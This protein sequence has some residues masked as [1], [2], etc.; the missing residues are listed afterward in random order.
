LFQDSCSKGRFYLILFLSTILAINYFLFRKASETSEQWVVSTSKLHEQITDLSEDANKLRTLDE[1]FEQ[2][3]KMLTL[4]RS[5]HEDLILQF[6]AV[7]PVLE[8][9][10]LYVREYKRKWSQTSNEN[11]H[12]RTETKRM[13][14]KIDD[15]HRAE[16]LMHA[17]IDDQET[18][19]AQIRKELK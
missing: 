19:L 8:K 11:R 10:Y 16:G 13:R 1:R 4:L 2:S 3:T 17:K 6:L 5:Q 14:S 18:S 15:F 9:A 12:L 7:K